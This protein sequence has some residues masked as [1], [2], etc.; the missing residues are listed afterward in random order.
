MRVVAAN[1]YVQDA[2]CDDRSKSIVLK[3][4]NFRIDHNSVDRWRPR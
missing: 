1:R 4:S 3:N 2:V